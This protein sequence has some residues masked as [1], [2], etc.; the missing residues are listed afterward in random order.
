[1]K[2]MPCNLAM[3]GEG[4]DMTLI[5]IYA[6]VPEFSVYFQYQWPPEDTAENAMRYEAVTI[7][8]IAQALGLSTQAGGKKRRRRSNKRKH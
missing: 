8:D 6:N 7:R 4:Q 2:G 1:M 3:K 5:F